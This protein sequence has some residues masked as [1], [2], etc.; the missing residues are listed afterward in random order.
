[1][2]LGNEFESYSHSF[3]VNHFELK[4]KATLGSKHSF[5]MQPLAMKTFVS[6]RLKKCL[7]GLLG[8]IHHIV[9]SLL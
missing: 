2:C 5:E 4:A 8:W 6:G 3:P 7:K 1:V 9:T